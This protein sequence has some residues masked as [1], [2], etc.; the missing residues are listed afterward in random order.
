MIQIKMNGACTALCTYENGVL[1]IERWKGRA[2]RPDQYW[3]V[4]RAYAT[5]QR[6]AAVKA[7]HCPTTGCR[8]SDADLVSVAM[9]SCETS[10][11]CRVCNTRR[12]VGRFPHPQVKV[13][14]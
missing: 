2:L 6:E 8:G 7:S 10:I 1:T 4:G 9:L 5:L 14:V 12:I 11:L 13:G 3:K